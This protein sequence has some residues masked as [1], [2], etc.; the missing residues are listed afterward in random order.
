MLLDDSRFP[1]VFLREHED[2][3]SSV[4]EVHGRNGQLESLLDRRDSRGQRHRAEAIV[5][6]IGNDFAVVGTPLDRDTAIIAAGLDFQVTEV[7][8][9]GIGYAG[10]FGENAQDQG[11][12]ADLRVRFRPDRNSASGRMAWRQAAD[13]ADAPGANPPGTQDQPETSSD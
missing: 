3:N 12:N 8:T 2:E 7:A 1:L 11:L 6:C 13:K 4:E 10:Q 5:G 9:T